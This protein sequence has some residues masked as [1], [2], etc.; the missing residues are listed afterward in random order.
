MTATRTGPPTAETRRHPDATTMDS[1]RPRVRVRPTGGPG[2]GGAAGAGGLARAPSA[3]EWPS[4]PPLYC[5]PPCCC[6]PPGSG[7]VAVGSSSGWPSAWRTSPGGVPSHPPPARRAAGPG[8]PRCR[9]TL[10]RA[11]RRSGGRGRRC[12]RANR[13]AGDR[14]PGRPARRRP[15]DPAA[16]AVPAARPEGGEPTGGD[17]AP[18]LR[19]ARPGPGHRRRHRRHVR[20]GSSPTGG[21]PGGTGPCSPVRCC[22]GSRS[23]E[24]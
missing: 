17:P 16:A 18:A 1:G 24:S 19:L 15:A 3:G 23:D 7:S 10:R 22:S 2:R 4:P 6:P 12:R 9:G 13:A 21:W 8:G 5:W 20:T 11:G 14:R